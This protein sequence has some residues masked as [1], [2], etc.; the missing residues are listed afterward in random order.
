[1]HSPPLSKDQAR[2]HCFLL[3]C[4]SWSA[5]SSGSGKSKGRDRATFTGHRG[6]FLQGVIAVG[7]FS[8]LA[9]AL[10]V[11]LAFSWVEGSD[12]QH[13]PQQQWLTTFEGLHGYVNKRGSAIQ[14]SLHK[15][16]M[17]TKYFYLETGESSLSR[18]SDLGWLDQSA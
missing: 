11:I 3:L 14:D 7:I 12:E 9:S 4:R 6:S 16:G 2:Y 17:N 13:E 10:G 8:I 1:M 5:P 15:A 18:E